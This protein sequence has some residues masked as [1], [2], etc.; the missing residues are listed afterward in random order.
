MK[1]VLIMV[2]LVACETQ[3]KVDSVGSCR[4]AYT[5]LRVVC[6]DRRTEALAYLQDIDARGFVCGDPHWY[7]SKMILCM[8]TSDRARA[9]R[10]AIDIWWLNNQ[11]RRAP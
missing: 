9:L 8:D 3:A 10:E 2:L 11:T 7:T 5:D 6:G 1:N 4:T